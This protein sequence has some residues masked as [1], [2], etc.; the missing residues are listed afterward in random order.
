MRFACRVVGL[1]L[2]SSIALSSEVVG[3]LV[4]DIEGAS[5]Y[6]HFQ[7]IGESNV[8]EVVTLK[9]LQISLYATVIT[10]TSFFCCPV[11]SFFLSITIMYHVPL[12][13]DALS[14]SKSLKK[15]VLHHHTVV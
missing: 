4:S 2:K 14:T 15:F 6:R 10:D 7:Q 1:R 8:N 12:S 9:S 3:W 13:Y 11:I 5:L